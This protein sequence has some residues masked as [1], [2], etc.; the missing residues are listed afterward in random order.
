[1]RQKR[2]GFIEKKRDATFH[3]RVLR[4]APDH[5]LFPV[6]TIKK[7]GNSSS[8]IFIAS[9]DSGGNAEEFFS[10]KLLNSLVEELDEDVES[11]SFDDVTVDFNALV[12]FES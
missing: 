9:F 12:V 7:K 11:D 3:L 4:Y 6:T 5:T 10:D 2:N 8:C 1:V